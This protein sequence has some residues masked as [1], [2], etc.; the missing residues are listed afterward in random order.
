MDFTSIVCGYHHS[1][2]TSMDGRIYTWGRNKN[3]QLGH[4]DYASVACPKL[5]KSLN[6]HSISQVA[7]GWQHTLALS[8]EGLVFSWV[9]NNDLVK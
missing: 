3:G 7:C 5:V 1:A 6:S 2:A 4:N 9:K 8:E